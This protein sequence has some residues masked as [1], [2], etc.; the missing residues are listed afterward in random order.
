MS[1]NRF[2]RLLSTDYITGVQAP[3]NYIP[4]PSLENGVTTGWSPVTLTFSG[5]VPVVPLTLAATQMSISTSNNDPIFGYHSLLLTK[6]AANAQY[7]GFISDIFYLEREDYAKVLYGSFSYEKVSGTVDFSGTSTQTYEIWIYDVQYSRFIQ[8][9]GWRGMNQGNGIGKVVFSFQSF[10]IDPVFGQGGYRVAIITQQTSTAASVVKFDDFELGTKPIVLGSA[11]TDWQSYTPTVAGMTATIQYAQYRRVGDSVQIQARF[12]NTAVSAT[13]LSVSLPSGLVIDSNKI[14][15]TGNVGHATAQT[16]V[17]GI[18]RF[19]VLGFV[20]GTV[21]NFGIN[22]SSGTGSGLL[23]ATDNL[24]FFA[25]VPIAGWG[26]FS[27][28]SSDTDT[29]VVAASYRGSGTQSGNNID[30]TFTTREIDTHAA[31]SSTTFTTPVSGQYNIGSVVRVDSQAAGNHL[32]FL[33][34]YVNGSQRVQIG[35]TPN[36]ATSPINTL[37]GTAMVQLNAGDTVTIRASNSGGASVTYSTRNVSIQRLTGSSVITA[38]ET[39]AAKY[40]AS[41]NG[42][43]NTT[44]PVNFDSKVYDTH[45]A[46]TTGASWKFTAPVSGKYSVKCIL[47]NSAVNSSGFTA[48]YKTGSKLESIGYIAGSIGAGSSSATI[49]LNAGEYIDV[50]QTGSFSWLGTASRSGDPCFIEIERVGN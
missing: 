24:S 25:Q 40:W 6:N 18:L 44:T 36:F 37:T 1:V 9:S 2:R 12:A 35:Y 14:P 39:V 29:R 38:T 19:N 46:V 48:I 3:R 17:S 32:H 30:L 20:G 13:T 7:Q 27:Q 22:L 15:I 33:D 4:N 28:V 5:G 31:F 49:E 34:I 26:S 10:A 47:N 23:A 45:N 8:P 43:T 42:T 16:G 21:L 11:M 41:A 50:R